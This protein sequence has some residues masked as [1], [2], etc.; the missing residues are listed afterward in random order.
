MLLV[1]LTGA[2]ASGKSLAA[3][4]FA[5]LGCYVLHSDQIAHELMQPQM[6]AWKEIVS[7][8]GKGILQPDSSIDRS[9]LG[10]I[11]F[12]QPQE[13]RFLDDLIHPLVFAHKQE[14]ISAL[15]QEQDTKIFISEAALTIEAGFITFFDKVVV[16]DCPREL[17]ITR[18]AQRDHISPDEALMRIESQLSPEKK[19]T[20]ADYVIDT[21]GT[22]AETIEQSERVFRYLDRDHQLLYG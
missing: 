15:K 18:L 3:Q 11:V 4:V 10:N 12:S 1:A 13:R 9:K 19:R 7:H 6:P 20:Y 5:D 2:I 22:I 14:I 8:F 16:T 17:L 21:S